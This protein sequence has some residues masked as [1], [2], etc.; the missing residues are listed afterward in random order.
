MCSM[1]LM[2]WTVL[3]SMYAEERIHL[4][5]STSPMHISHFAHHHIYEPS[6]V[7][8][9]IQTSPWMRLSMHVPPW[10]PCRYHP[11]CAFL[12]RWW[13]EDKFQ[14]PTSWSILT[15]DS[16]LFQKLIYRLIGAQWLDSSDWIVQFP[17]TTWLRLNTLSSTSYASTVLLFATILHSGGLAP[18]RLQ[19]LDCLCTLLLLRFT[20]ENNQCLLN[21]SVVTPQK[22]THKKHP[23]CFNKKMGTKAPLIHQCPLSILIFS[24]C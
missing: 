13:P 14:A 7:G 19:I 10:W 8:N 16:R 4:Y 12:D 21:P 1:F 22:W 17:C 18:S 23:F 15:N 20:A 5:H 11:P 9:T 3:G 24:F 6:W 2:L